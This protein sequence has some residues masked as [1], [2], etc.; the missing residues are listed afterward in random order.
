MSGNRE[1]SYIAEQ[2][3]KYFLKS[4]IIYTLIV[5]LKSIGSFQILNIYYLY[6]LTG[7]SVI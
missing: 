1:Y 4:V 7:L 6:E 3:V 2:V 5:G